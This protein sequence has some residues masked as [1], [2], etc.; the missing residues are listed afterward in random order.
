MHRHPTFAYPVEHLARVGFALLCPALS[1]PEDEDDPASVAAALAVDHRRVADIL[2]D[3]HAEGNANYAGV[4]WLGRLIS[5]PDRLPDLVTWTGQMS[6]A[7]IVKARVK[8]LGDGPIGDLYAYQAAAKG[9]TGLDGAT[10]QDALDAGFS[11]ATLDLAVVQRPA[12]E[13]LA[14]LGLESCP[15]VSFGKRDAGYL[16]DEFGDGRHALY[17]FTVEARDGG[18]YHRWGPLKRV[19]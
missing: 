6:L 10:C 8:M 17:R 11:A 2:R 19:Y 3:S 18:Y 9:T 4:K 1:P 14:I 7:K 13:L 12:L 16:W 15:L 5:W